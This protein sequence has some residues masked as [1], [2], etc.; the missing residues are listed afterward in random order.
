MTLAFFAKPSRLALA[1]IAILF[2]Y[3]A[4]GQGAPLG[5][6]V[7]AAHVLTVVNLLSQ[8]ILW[9]S[10]AM[11][12]LLVLKP[13]ITSRLL[14]SC[15][16]FSVLGCMLAMVYYPL[17]FLPSTVLAVYFFSFLLMF[18]IIGA[19]V[20]R[21]YPKTS[22]RA[23]RQA[24][25]AVG[26]LSVCALLI[27]GAYIISQ[28][29]SDELMLTYFAA[30]ELSSVVTGLAIIAAILFDDAIPIN[31]AAVVSV[32]Y[33]LVAVLFALTFEFILEPLVGAASTALGAE[34]DV[35]QT[36]LI[37]VVALTAPKLK[38]L[39]TPFVEARILDQ[40]ESLDPGFDATEQQ[41]PLRIT[42]LV[43]RT[44]DA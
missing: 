5:P 43:D 9:P 32:S 28:Y 17:L 36:I 13:G 21:L 12:V 10:L 25:W 37:V 39:I 44:C 33:A 41:S 23:R 8:L 26:A 2:L 4:A 22:G 1:A 30:S 16:G 6:S 24:N 19:L 14:L 42:N 29:M 20:L 7:Y 31:K 15:W 40:E 27:T 35:G 38:N 18:V 3:G 11:A 34:S